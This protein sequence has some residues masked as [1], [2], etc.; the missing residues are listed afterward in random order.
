MAFRKL[1]IQMTKSEVVDF[2][3]NLLFLGKDS[4]L[5]KDIGFLGRT[6][7]ASY[8]GLIRDSETD[9]FL[10]INSIT[11]S[12]N[13]VNDISALDSS[14]V[15][16]DIKVG[17]ITATE[18]IGDVTGNIVGNVSGNLTGNLTGNVTGDVVG[19]LT[20][21]VTG[22]VEGN[23]TISDTFVLPKMTTAERDAISSPTRGQMIYNTDTNMFSGWN[24]TSWV[25]L[26]PSTFTETP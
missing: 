7:A 9:E 24:G 17:Q 26:V 15:L 4:G 8:S 19:D 16:A 18:F 6:G 13:T 2:S 22:N 5:D 14:M 11:L 3:D 12:S 1:N 20:G 10:L 23:V 25:Q 21:N